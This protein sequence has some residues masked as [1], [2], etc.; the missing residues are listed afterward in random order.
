MPLNF[1]YVEI[2]YGKAYQVKF[3]SALNNKLEAK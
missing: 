2:T 3:S 1:N